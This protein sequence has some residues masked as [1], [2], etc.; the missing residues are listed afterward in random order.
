MCTGI[1]AYYKST[2]HTFS[3]CAY[4]VYDFKEHIEEYRKDIRKLAR[5]ALYN[6]ETLVQEFLSEGF[7]VRGGATLGKVYYESG[8][9]LIFGPGINR[10]YT[11]ENEEAKFPRILVDDCVVD[12]VN[13]YENEDFEK[14]IRDRNIELMLE[15]QSTNGRIIIEDDDGRYHL[16]YFNTIQ[17][18]NFFQPASIMIKQLRKLIDKN[19]SNQ[20]PDPSIREKYIWLE[21][22]LNNSIPED[23]IYDD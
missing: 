2:I 20:S 19:I 15:K 5:I 23:S 21:N 12:L 4:I 13:K 9:S 8:R 1:Y 10:A 22:Y 18:G 16:N 6:T 11:L 17:T 3:D 14:D 7:L